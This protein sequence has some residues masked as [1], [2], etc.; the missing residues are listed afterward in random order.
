MKVLTANF[1]TC[2][3]K[4]CKASPASYPL[5]FRDAELE[6]SELDFQPDFIRNIL[7]R[8]DWD[9]LVVT[10]GEL[11]FTSLTPTKPEGDAVTDEL[12]RELHRFLLETQVMEGKMVCGNCGHEY[13]IKEGIANFLLPSHLGT[14]IYHFDICDGIIGNQTR[15]EC[16]IS[17][18][19]NA[20]KTITD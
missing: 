7:P 1:V 20:L 3:I 6:Q 17:G 9:A 14:Y 16:H 19:E 5:H 15:G 11:G 2:A 12:L 18:V 8:I 4:A 10:A 13:R